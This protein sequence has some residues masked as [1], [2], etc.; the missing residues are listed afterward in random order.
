MKITGPKGVS[1]QPSSR[2]ARVD[3]GFSVGGAD[4]SGSASAAAP[5][6]GASGV[7]SL[8]ALMALQELDTVEE[9]RRKAI[10]RG[11]GL[12]DR[13]DALKVAMLDGGGG[14]SAL[15]ALARAV[16]EER[17]YAE[18]AGLKDVL[19]HIETR[20]AVELAKAGLR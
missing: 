16:A 11:G 3:G 20:A 10:R 8:A 13:L 6:S 2:S 4:R 19:D 15:Q 5:M 17:R 9:R 12:L 18:H 7:G 1:S 14:A